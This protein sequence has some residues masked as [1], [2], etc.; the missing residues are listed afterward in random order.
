MENIMKKLIAAVVLLSASAGAFAAVPAATH[1]M[2]DCPC[3][4]CPHGK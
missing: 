1:A 2:T 3:P 4:D